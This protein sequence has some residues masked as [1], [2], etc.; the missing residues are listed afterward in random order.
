[1]F[2]INKQVHWLFLLINIL[3]ITNT[4]N[5]VTSI[6]QEVPHGPCLETAKRNQVPILG[7]SLPQNPNKR[8]APEGQVVQALI[9][10]HQSII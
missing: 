9:Q 4:L 3:G 10:P 6:E 2:C 8:K 7:T 1:M 5:P